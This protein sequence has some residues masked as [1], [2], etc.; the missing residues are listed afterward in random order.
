ML[1]KLN[2]DYH[3]EKNSLQN[4]LHML[5]SKLKEISFDKNESFRAIKTLKKSITSKDSQSDTEKVILNL[6]IPL[7]VSYQR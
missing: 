7:G 1:K 2:I 6:I 5:N 3:K 4:E